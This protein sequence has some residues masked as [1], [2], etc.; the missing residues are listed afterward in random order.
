MVPAVVNDLRKTK[1]CNKLSRKNA[2][3]GSKFRDS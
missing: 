2:V 3:K 1:L